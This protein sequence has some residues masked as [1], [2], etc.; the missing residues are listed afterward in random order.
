MHDISVHQSF[1]SRQL[2]SAA[3]ALISEVIELKS[4]ASQD[5]D[6]LN[7]TRIRDLISKLSKL[8]DD[9]LDREACL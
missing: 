1:V 9:M 3:Y 2:Y 7:H 5:I 4:Y 6:L 8:T